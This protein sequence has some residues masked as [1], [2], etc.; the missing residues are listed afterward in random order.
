[1]S[2]RDADTG[3]RI[4]EGRRILYLAHRFPYPPV[5]GAKVRACYSIRRLAA[6]N[7]V[8]VAAPV[9]DA[10]EAAAARELADMG[11]RVE[12][13]PLSRSAALLRTAFSALTLRTAS[14]GYFHAPSLARR[15]QSLLRTEPFDLVIV[16]S[17]SIA[18]YVEDLQGV[19]KVL[20]F[21]DMDSQKWRDY[22]THVAVAKRPVYAL[23]GWT[24]ARLERR[25]ARRFDLNVVAT[26]F[27]ADSLRQIA[28]AVPSAIVANGVDL[29]YFQPSDAPVDDRLV[30][31]TGRMDYLPNVQ[32][33][34]AFCA[35][36]WPQVRA[37]LPDA[38]LRI[39]GAAP[40][41][42]IRALHGQDGI[43]VT[44]TVSD[45]RPCVRAAGCA[46]A[47]LQIARGTQNKVLE[48]MA[49]GI[50]VVASSLAAR[51]VDAR[52][53]TDLLVADAPQETA[54]AIS[55]LLTEPGLR[56][57]LAEA[58]RARVAAH[59]DWSTTLD[60]LERRLADLLAD[61]PAAAR[62]GT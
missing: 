32:G 56:D 35:Q 41:P 37:R 7:H 30:C 13:A 39:V 48:A 19:V 60:C 12:T 18:P 57:R 59:H 38:R 27:E 34:R 53:G 28:G 10:D 25:L 40:A 46:V 54:E 58:G 61:A 43:E 22:C 3:A 33:M 44:G 16:H 26:A 36:V 31:F 52:A 6:A 49:M 4:L 55:R 5:G 9:R 45:V 8:T 47:P 20:D 51:G 17:S 1:M 50:P 2:P 42:A 14:A 24:L 11:V 21:V 15:V 23:E 29:E 62:K